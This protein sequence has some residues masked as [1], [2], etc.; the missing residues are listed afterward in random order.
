MFSTGGQPRSKS[1]ERLIFFYGKI[2]LPLL[3]S[4]LCTASDVVVTV[5]DTVVE[6]A[7]TTTVAISSASMAHRIVFAAGGD[8]CFY[9]SM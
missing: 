6:R 8:R 4:I 7:D 3:M 2:V 9:F 1:M 5:S